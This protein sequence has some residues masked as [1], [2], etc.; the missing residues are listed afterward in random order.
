MIWIRN[1]L[2]WRIFRVPYS[3][4]ALKCLNFVK[5][6]ALAAHKGKGEGGQNLSTPPQAAILLQIRPLYYSVCTIS[7]VIHSLFTCFFYTEHHF[8]EKSWTKKTFLGQLVTQNSTFP[9]IGM[10]VKIKSYFK[11]TDQIS[12]QVWCQLK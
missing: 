5:Q 8:I 2:L 1:V 12:Y 11:N 7:L 9:T 10:T 4:M 6:D 3:N